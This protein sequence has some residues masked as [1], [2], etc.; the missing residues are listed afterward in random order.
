MSRHCVRLSRRLLRTKVTNWIQRLW[1]D[2]KHQAVLA[3]ARSLLSSR[4]SM[5]AAAGGPSLIPSGPARVG[6]RGGG[7]SCVAV[8]VL[9]SD[10]PIFADRSP[11]DRFK[12]VRFPDEGFS[13][14]GTTVSASGK[15]FKYSRRR[16]DAESK[17]T[18]MPV[19]AMNANTAPHG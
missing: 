19:A 16:R 2:D 12:S 15:V 17:K 14:I 6:R 4:L 10:F 7:D 18:P 9:P 5:Q 8:R 3:A 11:H 1:S 13:P